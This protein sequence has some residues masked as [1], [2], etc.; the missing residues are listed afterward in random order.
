MKAYVLVGISKRLPKKHLVEILPG[1]RLIDLVVENLENI[2]FKVIIYS[3]YRF[4]T[5][6]EIIIDKNPWILP[7]LISL[8]SFDSEFL[9]VGGD[10]PLVKKE[11][12]EILTEKY[13]PGFTVVPQ[14]SHTGYLE[15]LHAIYSNT[16][17]S[18]LENARSLTTGLQNCPTTKFILAED[19]PPDSFF[20][21]NTK[22]DLEKL[23]RMLYRRLPA[24]KF[25]DEHCKPGGCGENEVN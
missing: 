17:I 16:S 1:K 21:V 22:K 4:Y 11:A 18:C 13:E 9:L 10:M 20:N 6:T 14:W 15:P 24:Q 5:D 12:V 25:P 2:G 8:L 3:K 19:M 23:R 7:S